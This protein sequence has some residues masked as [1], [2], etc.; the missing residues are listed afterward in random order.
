MASAPAL[1]DLFPAVEAA[2]TLGLF[3]TAERQAIEKL[4]AYGKADRP[5]IRCQ[6]RQKDVPAKPE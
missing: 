2:A 6:V 1:Q 4:L 5:V 3:G